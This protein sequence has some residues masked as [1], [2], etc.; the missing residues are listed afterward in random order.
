MKKAKREPFTLGDTTVQPGESAQIDLEVGTFVTHEKLQL[1]A[2]VIH[3]KL[4]GP[5][6]LISG[7]IH[8]DEFNGAEIIRR[9][10]RTKQ[11]AK[12]K[13]TLLA[14]PIVNRP[15]FVRRSRYMPD[16]R[17]LNRLFP[18]SAKGSLG[19][20]LAKVF[21]DELV[22]RADLV[23]DLHTGAVNRSNMPQIRLTEGDNTSMEFAKVFAPPV[24][25]TSSQRESTLRAASIDLETPILLY[26][27][28]EALRLDASAIRFG[29]QGI[30]SVM[31]HMG[32]LSSRT[33]S[34]RK[35]S[36]IVISKKSFWER[37]P[38]GGIF[39]PLMSLGK[40]VNKGDVLGFIADPQANNEIEVKAN[41][42]G[43]IIGR[44]NEAIADEGDGLFH[45][46]YAA[47]I[48]SA[49]DMIMQSTEAL[50][51]PIGDQDDHPVPY[52]A[53]SDSIS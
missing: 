41:Y 43:I 15:G 22:T 37:A 53:A 31:R 25:L 11:V 33:R 10:L 29:V 28:G 19:A 34:Q 45:I 36:P 42:P 1:Q 35:K 30:L 48:E 17:D 44:T 23:I 21:T 27:A 50:P 2:T 13:G 6:L 47:D 5:T 14:V 3:G 7:C 9:I 32:M 20:R 24:I 16:R 18:G 46:A 8:G 51:D 4:P 38:Q 40:A 49:E 39:I 12:L 26:E 52:D